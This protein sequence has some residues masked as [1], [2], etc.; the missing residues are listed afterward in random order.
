[1]LKNGLWVAKAVVTVNGSKTVPIK[2]FNPTNDQIFIPRG[3]VIAT[4]EPFNN[5]F[6]LKPADQSDQLFVQNVQL[7]H[8]ISDV[9]SEIDSKFLSYFE[10][11][12]HLSLTE[13]KQLKQCL[14]QHKTLFVTAENPNLG[15]TDIVQHKICLKPDYKPK[16]QQPL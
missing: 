10:I 6:T 12:D 15:Y 13:Q 14:N 7:E 1:M 4:F 11:P 9:D 5:D 8:E 2:I 3:K 16:H